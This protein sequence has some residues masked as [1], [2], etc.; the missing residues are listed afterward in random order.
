[1]S[2]ALLLLSG[3]IDS[4][5]LAYYLKARSDVS[6]LYAITYLYGQKHSRELDSAKWHASRLEL[7]EHRVVD[8]SVFGELTSGGSALTDS[9][10]EIP[11][12]GD[13]SEEAARQPPTY[14]PNRNMMLL[15]MAAAYAESNGIFA[16]YYGAQASDEVGY[17]DCTE[18]F[19][20]RIND[21]L[22]LNR[23]QP[24]HVY[25][26]FVSWNKAD[27]V[28]LGFD[29]GVEYDQT[30]SCYRGGDEPCG[31]CP[32]CVERERAFKEARGDASE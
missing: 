2:S 8:L 14:V 27:V 21:V 24:V 7:A 29:L 1:M 4:T 22:A 19:L 31:T 10:I 5:T 25:A 16:V 11:R 12:S 26:P 15:A 23:R 30:W 28:R 17:W 18:D 9:E 6:E 32:S 13:L 20:S 3:G